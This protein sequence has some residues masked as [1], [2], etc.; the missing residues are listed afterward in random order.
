M[1]NKKRRSASILKSLIEYLMMSIDEL[2]AMQEASQFS[3]GSKIAFIECL[4]ITS[5][6][7]GY[8]KF[9]VENI[10]QYFNIK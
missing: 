5:E 8:H 1:K 2:N 9:G 4:E 6:W 3:E 10:E 7:T